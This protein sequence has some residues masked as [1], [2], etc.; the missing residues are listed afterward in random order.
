MPEDL[1]EGFAERYDLFLGEFGVHDEVVVSFYRRLFQEHKVHRLLDCACGTGHD[2]TLFLQLGC[3]VVGSDISPS[4]LAQARRNLDGA[5]LEVPL[6]RVDYRHLPEYF[7]CPFDAVVCLSSSILHLPDEDEAG[8][9]FRSMRDVLRP[10][11]ILVLTQGTSDRQWREKPRFLLALDT[12]EVTRLFV[13][14]YEGQGACY[15]IVDVDHR[16]PGGEL[17][18]WSTDYPRVLLRDDYARLLDEAG[19]AAVHF[20]GGYGFQPYDRNESRRLI[21]VAERG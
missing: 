4:M 19:F 16:R 18:V 2:L 5:G 20:Y 17:K 13:I 6:H 15:N 11:G 14:D 12:P 3:D 10:G 7:G 9:A 1:Y 8:K 21:V